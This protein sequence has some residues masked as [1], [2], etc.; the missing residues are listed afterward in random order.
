MNC[1]MM[2]LKYWRLMST[3]MLLGFCCLWAIAVPPLHDEDEGNTRR[4]WNK[5]FR[6]ARDRTRTR[7]P[8][9][10]AVGGGLIGFTI[11]RLRETN[12]SRPIAERATTDTLFREGEQVR[13]SIEVPQESDGY[14]YVIDREVY[15]DGT[16]SDPYLIFPSQTTPPR[17][18]IVTAGKPVYVPAQGDTNPYFT[19]ERSRRDHILE[20]LTI[21]VSPKP[22]KLP[23]ETPDNPT[24]LNR[25][26]VARW[27][28]QWGGRVERREARD[29]AG[30]QWSDAEREADGGQRRLVQGDPLPQTIFLV[31][32]KPGEPMMLHAPLHIAR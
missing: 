26:Q 21:I 12:Q 7:R 18:N 22:L 5:R 31:K 28:R 6:E 23:L 11:W 14:L 27:E 25:V 4:I 24:R 29:G 30:K 8:G 1:R 17:G 20:K 10:T 2:V 32:F 13:L 9:G 19:L 15:E 16:T 3:A